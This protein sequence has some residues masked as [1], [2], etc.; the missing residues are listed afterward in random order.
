MVHDQAHFELVLCLRILLRLEVRAGQRRR[1]NTAD[2]G[3]RV[4][5][6]LGVALTDYLLIGSTRLVET[7]LRILTHEHALVVL[8]VSHFI[9]F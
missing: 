9:L 1:L 6:L 7:A 8:L 2:N 5:F 3:L 4:A